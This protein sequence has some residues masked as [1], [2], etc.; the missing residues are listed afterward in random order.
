M[1]D[2]LQHFRNYVYIE[3]L[4]ALVYVLA[5]VVIVSMHAVDIKPG[6]AT[7]TLYACFWCLRS[8]Y[9]GCMLTIHSGLCIAIYIYR[10]RL[11]V[12]R[13]SSHIHLCR[14]NVVSVSSILLMCC[15]QRML[16]LLLF[17]R[18]SLR[19][20]HYAS[21]VFGRHRTWSVQKRAPFEFACPKCILCTNAVQPPHIHVK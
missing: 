10:V 5:T 2:N 20:K 19:R 3:C 11:L 7:S 21:L 16:W 13:H 1:S 18:L 9:C 4:L 6:P 17:C 15:A 8:A 14:K 12:E